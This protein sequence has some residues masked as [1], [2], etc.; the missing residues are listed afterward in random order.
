MNEPT[1]ARLAAAQAL[2]AMGEVA[3]GA[4]EVAQGGGGKATTDPD[5]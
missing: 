4:Q 2:F 3:R 5:S 1:P